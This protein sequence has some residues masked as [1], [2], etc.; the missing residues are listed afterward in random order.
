MLNDSVFFKLLNQIFC[1][2]IGFS[3]DANAN[4]INRT[5]I[6]IILAYLREI[7]AFIA[8]TI[9]IIWALNSCL[10]GIWAFFDANSILKNIFTCCP[11]IWL[12]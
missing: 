10:L 8:N 11:C 2:I 5:I 7:M 4:N 9:R 1:P 6:Y 3:W 12:Q